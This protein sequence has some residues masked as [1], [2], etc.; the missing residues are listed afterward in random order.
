MVFLKRPISPRLR[1]TR[2]AGRWLLAAGRLVGCCLA[3][4]LSGCVAPLPPF[5]LGGEF[6]REVSYLDSELVIISEDGL[7]DPDNRII[8]PRG[9]MAFL[10]E[11]TTG[12]VTVRIAGDFG[13]LSSDHPGL[14][15]MAPTA[16]GLAT[17]EPLP[18]GAVASAPMP[19]AG[20]YRYEVQVGDRV[21]VGQFAVREGAAVAGGTG[22][23]GRGPRPDDS[24]E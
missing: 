6:G 14:L 23:N 22:R 7:L 17:P 12:P 19:A 9:A 13:P 5:F 18:V 2:L 15:R 20:V 24:G 3:G 1:P 11:A 8:H 16:Q 4:A 21:L 10:N